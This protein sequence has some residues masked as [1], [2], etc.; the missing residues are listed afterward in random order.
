MRSK[1]TAAREKFPNPV[2]GS[3][4]PRDDDDSIFAVM[5][6]P[7]PR[8][9]PKTAEGVAR[10]HWNVGAHAMP[11]G[12]ERDRNFA[13]DAE[14]GR[15]YVLKF[16]NPAEDPAVT[17]LQVRALEHVATADPQFP[18]PRVVRQPNGAAEAELPQPDGTAL[19]ARLLTWL[20][21]TSLGR[22]PH[23]PAQRRALGQGLARLDLALRDFSHP[24]GPHPLI[25]DVA[26][27]SRLRELLSYLESAKARGMVATTL[28]E[29]ESRVTPRWALLRRQ[30]VHNDLSPSNTL[31]DSGNPDRFA[32]LIDFGDMVET[33][34]VV[35]V[36]VGATGQLGEDED[37]IEA[38]AD[39]VAGFQDVLPL[40]ATE[41][42]VL[43][44]I[45]AARM[46]QDLVL[47][48]WHR[49]THPDNPRFRWGDD[50]EAGY[51]IETSRQLALIATAR[52]PAATSA[53]RRAC[54]VP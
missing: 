3:R 7:A 33:A 20:P 18:V 45:V 41:T 13:L 44:S 31:V 15:R 19:R 2:G 30:V 14:D 21:G 26:Q 12:G 8:V 50:S 49:K 24:A 46:C 39:F 27:A 28:D 48:A 16:A 25:W 32:G 6:L 22:A 29:F 51:A 17:D 9:S 34:L 4:S 5:T 43:P 42:S 10:D 52:S 1:F 40:T 35:D 54:G 11:L 47:P 53:L 23:T 36:A 37:P 38:M